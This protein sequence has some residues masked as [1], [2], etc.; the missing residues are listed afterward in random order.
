MKITRIVIR[1]F[2]VL[3]DREFEFTPGA[4]VIEGQNERGKTSLAMFIKF[5]LYGLDAKKGSPTEKERFKNWQTHRAD[6]VME[7]TH[8]GRAYRLERTV[9]EGVRETKK[10]TDMESLT[11]VKFD[12][13]VGEYLLGVPESVFVNTVF[14]RQ[15]ASGAV[16][17]D[18]VRNAVANILSSADENIDVEK[19]TKKLD[20][21]RTKLRHK[22]SVGGRLREIGREIKDCEAELADSVASHE[23]VLSAQ[24]DLK[25]KQAAISKIE[26]ENTSL[27]LTLSLYDGMRRREQRERMRETLRQLGEKKARL[28]QLDRPDVSVHSYIANIRARIRS[29][30]SAVAAAGD[31]LGALGKWQAPRFSSDECE[32]DSIE[33]A[34]LAKRARRPKLMV[35]F[36]IFVIFLGVIGIVACAINIYADLTPVSEIIAV[37]P[38]IVFLC[39][40]GAVMLVRSSGAKKKLRALLDRWGVDDIGDLSAAIAAEMELIASERSHSDELLRAQA[41]LQSAGDELGAALRDA[42]ALCSGVAGD[43]DVSDDAVVGETTDNGITGDDAPRAGTAGI[44]PYDV[45][46]SEVRRAEA[47]LS[48]F[49]RRRLEAE[50]EFT[51]LEGE[52]KELYGKCGEMEKNLRDVDFAAVDALMSEHSSSAE[53]S[54]AASM[55]ETDCANAEKRLRFNREKLRALEVQCDALK[56]SAY[57]SPGRAPAQLEEHL[58]AL[59][60]ELAGGELRLE[61]LELAMETVAKCSEDLRQDLIPQIAERASAD[62]AKATAMRHDRLALGEDFKLH[63][64]GE[65]GA[66][67]ADYLSSGGADAAYV[68]LRRALTPALYRR[69]APCAIYDESFASV[70][71]ERTL[72]LISMIAADSA[73]SLI[74]TCRRSDAERIAIELSPA[75]NV[76]RL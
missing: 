30:Q 64:S 11:G 39:A 49:E 63:C 32:V 18:A 15:S 29:A 43:D 6:G 12:G 20:A 59:R 33:A 50:R 24:S 40:T 26:S 37:L 60:R 69:E 54:C 34:E 57:S 3:V 17:S 36:S 21:A 58:A 14:V 47:L 5:M 10:L 1:S 38:V 66:F 70:D 16:D 41:R 8:E 61:A 35:I 22:N 74:F 28:E 71:E 67:S 13:E 9:G 55:A 68:C 51:E 7:F 23:N 53:Y 45:A 65:D 46:D 19:I 31:D 44:G 52:Y 72:R 76:I 75:V 42:F 4:N 73:Q 25:E 62:F 27:S 2:G 56:R 48:E